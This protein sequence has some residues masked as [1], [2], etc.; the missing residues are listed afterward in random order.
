MSKTVILL[1]LGVSTVSLLGLCW[2]QHQAILKLRAGR[3]ALSCEVKALAARLSS[4]E[5]TVGRDAKAKS[6][7]ADVVANSGK[8]WSDSQAKL[9]AEV[10]VEAQAQPEEAQEAPMAGLAKMM[11][12][13]GMKDMIRAQQKGQQDMMYGSFFKCLQLPEADMASLKS[14]LL[15][16]QMALVDSSMD[17]ISGEATPEAEKAA[18]EK[19]KE[20]TAAYDAQIKALLG[21]DNY[22]LFKSFEE[23]QAERMQ[24]TMFKGSLAAGDQLTDEQEDSLI[25]SMHEAR[26]SFTFSVPELADQKAADPSLFTPERITK[27]LEESAKLQEQYVAEAAKVLNPAQL[28]LFKANQKQQQAMQEMGLKMAAKMFGQP[29]KGTAAAAQ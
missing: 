1:V 28:E 7:V 6:K 9:A 29:A 15:D 16:R 21:D 11:K 14:L 12:N 5:Q 18:A 20:T 17:I 13:P 25:R 22:T 26:N 4:L 2:A 8:A 3:E 23:T 27:M 19:I 24:V 10:P